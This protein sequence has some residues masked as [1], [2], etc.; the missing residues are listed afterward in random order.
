MVICETVNQE[1]WASVE[2]H[3]DA[4]R[5]LGP[6]QRAAGLRA[7]ADEDV[8]REVACLL[9]HLGDGE[10]V[11]AV[12]GS[13]AASLEPGIPDQRIGP[14]R[15]V[16]HLGHGGQGAVFEAVRDDGRFEQRVAIKIVKWD[17][18]SEPAR[19]RFRD[20]RQILAGLEHPNIARLL[21]GGETRSGAPYLAMEFIDGLP[22]VQATEGWTTRRKLELFLKVAEAVAAAHRKLIVHRDLKPANILV[23]RDGSPKLLDFGI[24]KLLD[25]QADRTLTAFQALTP[26]YASPEQVRGLPISTASD[27]YSLGV[28]LYQVLTGRRPYQLE[29]STPLEMDRVICQQPPAP[30]GLNG[31]LDA[32]LA[33]ALRKEPERRYQGVEPLAEDIR[34]Y[35]E[36]RPIL[37]RPDTISY[38]ARKYV[39]RHWIGLLAAAIALGGILGGAGVAVYQARRAQREFNQVRQLANR[40]LFD[41]D[42]EIST[43]PGTVKAREMIVSTALDYLNRLAGEASGDPGLKWELAVA[44]GKVASVQGSMSTP[45]L[46]RP[47]DGTVSYGRAFALAR[48]LAD[49]H[50][51]NVQH[52]MLV[53]AETMDRYLKD[54]AVAKRLGQEAIDRSTSLSLNY[55]GGALGE[56]ANT[57]GISGDLAGSLDVF[58]RLVPLYR[59]AVQREPS[60]GNRRLLGVAL[61]NMGV[62]CHRLTLFAEANAG[63]TEALT[64]FR[65]LAA[66]RPGSMKQELFTALTRLG[67]VAG[68]GDRP[69]LGDSA[70]A[71]D[72]YEQAIAALE[73]LLAA[74]PKDHLSRNDTA[75]V[76]EKIAR[77]LYEVDPGRAI[78]HSIQAAELLDAVAPDDF[79]SR[80]AARISEAEAH[81]VLGEFAA[82][83]RLLI[84]AGNVLKAPAG[85]AQ[86]PSWIGRGGTWKA[87]AGSRR[88]LLV[89]WLRRFRW[90]SRFFKMRARPP[91]PGC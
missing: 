30:A 31:E 61:T 43:I 74:D 9:S 19:R 86:K 13:V 75:L 48:P 35:L 72:Y 11:A 62:A 58:Q 16:R 64:I 33:M 27:V 76:H 54:F 67:D 80:A 28:V 49:G 56:M 46:R 7:I 83:E 37:A 41:F 57:L 90:K 88:R 25:A 60:L 65:S 85:E 47:R 21:D 69:S 70:A 87:R 12:V 68:A 5:D 84:A 4:L 73:P 50:L 42:N 53:Q 77:A 36:R 52:S 38:R 89:G 79:D 8:R 15:L 63:H 17:I 40:F 20:E 22:L 78:L 82:A 3:F 6:E 59:E 18:D 51:L 23:T 91:T 10:T 71:A 24:A 29:T 81:R 26:E 45:S 1:A 55:R 32:I 66:E 34:R 14:Y 39:R 44:F 2:A